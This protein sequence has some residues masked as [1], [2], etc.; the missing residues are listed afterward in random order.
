MSHVSQKQES[1]WNFWS[2]LEKSGAHSVSHYKDYSEKTTTKS[3]HT[4]EEVRGKNNVQISCTTN[5]SSFV[6]PPI[7]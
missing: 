4:W 1:P 2:R 7:K 5:K 3:I 6:C